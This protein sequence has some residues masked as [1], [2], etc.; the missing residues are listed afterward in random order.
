MLIHK[1]EGKDE[2]EL[3]KDV[4]VMTGKSGQT[5]L[6]Q[7]AIAELRQRG[8][9]ML[10]AKFWYFDTS[11]ND[12]VYCSAHPVPNSWS[13]PIRE[14]GDKNTL[15]IKIQKNPKVCSASEKDEQAPARAPSERPHQTQEGDKLR[16][17]VK[18]RSLGVVIQ[19]VHRW[20]ALY[21]GI[22]NM[23]G[24]R[25]RYTL[26]QAAEIVDIPKKTLDDYLQQIKTGKK[27]GFDFDAEKDSKIGVLRDFNEQHKR[28]AKPTP[29]DSDDSISS[30]S[31]SSSSSPRDGS[32]PPASPKPS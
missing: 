4:D 8:Y 15:T 7:S 17:R 27:Y 3:V 11:L 6:F 12:F 31:S 21:N 16:S 32:S 23:N 5:I 19:K 10:R 26:Q 14:L 28:A 30:S 29:S 13:I 20:R 25:L 9:D 2:R 22:I 1:E 18:E 24:E